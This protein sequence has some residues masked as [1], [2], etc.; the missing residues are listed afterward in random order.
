MRRRDR[1][2]AGA[3]NN[4]GATKRSPRILRRHRIRRS[5]AGVRRRSACPFNYPR[6]SQPGHHI[7]LSAYRH[8][9]DLRHGQSAGSLSHRDSQSG[10]PDARLDGLTMPRE[11]L[12][13]ADVFRRFR[14]TFGSSTV[15]PFQQAR[16]C[17]MI[18]IE[19][20]RTAALGGHVERCSACG[21]QRIACHF[22]FCNRNCP[23]CQG[24]ARARIGYWRPAGGTARRIT[25]YFHVVILRADGDRGYRVPEPDSDLRHPVPDWRSEYTAPCIRRS[26]TSGSRDR[27]PRCIPRVG[28]KPITGTLTHDT[29]HYRISSIFLM[30][31]AN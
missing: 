12:E 3:R 5:P 6:A 9:Q 16:R 18:P 26:R 28:T 11:G 30:N 19:S 13:A 23:K 7:S 4:Q 31:M 29:W 8:Q 25:P 20:C 21:H 17:A 27:L 2:Q 10:H 1:V 22:H 24:L 14:Q 15:T